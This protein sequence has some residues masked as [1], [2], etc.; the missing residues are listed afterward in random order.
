MSLPIFNYAKSHP[1]QIAIQ[2]EN[3]SY[4]YGN[5]LNAAE[6]FAHTL[7]QNEADLAERRVAYMVKPGFD[8]V[9]NQWGI[10][11]A[12][13]VVVPLCITYP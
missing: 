3:Q 1:N 4:T 13:G 2:E 6:S 10:W 8:Y 9:R 5:L 12:G 11:L 7:L